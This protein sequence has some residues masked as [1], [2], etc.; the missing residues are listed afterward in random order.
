MSDKRSSNLPVYSNQIFFFVKISCPHNAVDKIALIGQEKKPL[1]IFV[2]PAYKG[3]ILMGYPEILSYCCFL[4]LALFL[5]TQFLWFNK[6]K[7]NLF[8]SAET[9]FPVQTDP[10]HRRNFF[11]CSCHFSVDRDPSKHLCIVCFPS[12]ADSCLSLGYLLILMFS[13]AVFL[14]HLFHYIII[15]LSVYWQQSN[16]GQGCIFLSHIV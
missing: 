3:K 2:Q 15:F 8:V 4:S 7:K 14:V 5:C 9:G 12:G 6:K 1:G 13:I 10:G 16:R 11:S